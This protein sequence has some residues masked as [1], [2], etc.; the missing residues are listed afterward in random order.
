MLPNDTFWSRSNFIILT[1]YFFITTEVG[2]YL[3]INLWFLRK[4]PKFTC[5]FLSVVLFIFRA[6]VSLCSWRSLPRAVFD[7]SRNALPQETLRDEIKPAA[8][9]TIASGIGGQVLL[10]SGGGA[11]KVPRA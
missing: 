4:S 6:V 10:F 5:D 3:L 11:N 8:R 7:W 1:V 9:K 2:F